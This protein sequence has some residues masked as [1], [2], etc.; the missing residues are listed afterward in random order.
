MSEVE[1]QPEKAEAYKEVSTEEII[2][3]L[4]ELKEQGVDFEEEDI[5]LIL[6]DLE[7]HEAIGYL[8][9]ALEQAEFENPEEFLKEKGILE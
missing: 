4:R 7:P 8:I 5:E 3:I 6:G 2:N 9:F 1:P